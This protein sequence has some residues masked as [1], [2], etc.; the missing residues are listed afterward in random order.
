MFCE[1]TVQP[2]LDLIGQALTR[3]L[4]R[5]ATARTWRS[6]FPDCSPRNL[7][8]R[9]K[10]DELDARLGLRTFNEIRKSRGLEPF[11]DP[12]FDKPMLPCELRRVGPPA[13]ASSGSTT[14]AELSTVQTSA[15]RR[16]ATQAASATTTQ[17]RCSRCPSTVP[18][19]RPARWP[20]T[21][22]SCTVAASSRPS[23]PTGP[24]TSS[25]P[26][27]LR[28]AEEYPAQPGRAVGAQPRRSSRRSACA[29][30]STCS[31]DGS[32]PRRGSP[33]GVPFA[34]DVFR[35]YEQG[36]LRGWSIGFVPRQARRAAAPRRLDR[37]ARR[38]VGPARIL[39]GADPGEPRGADAGRREG[40]GPRPRAAATG[41]TSDDRG[42]VL[43][44]LRRS[45]RVAPRVPGDRE[46]PQRL[47]HSP[48][49]R[50]GRLPTCPPW[51]LVPCPFLK[52]GVPMS[53]TATVP[54][55]Q[56]PVP[57]R[58]GHVHRGASRH[59][60]REGRR[61]VERRV[62][63]VTSGPVV[64]GLGRVQRAEGRR[65]RARLRRPR[66]GQGRDP[67]PPAAPRPVRGL[68]VHAA[69]RAA[70][71]PGAAGHGPPAGVRA[72]RP[73][74]PRRAAPEDDRPRRPVRPGRGRLDRPPRR[75]PAQGAR[76]DSAT[77]PAAR[78]CRCRCSAS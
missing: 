63:W 78:W 64:P 54:D 57:R 58:A 73:A 5:R 77:P 62:P 51:F 14:S 30:G 42:S 74:A 60:R 56:V 7:D 76:H 61:R 20:S 39:G 55:R 28:N 13:S 25:I 33:S 49:G 26:T 69:P 67:R 36:V 32:S 17:P 29:S 11:A 68:R 41:C 22:T 2:K 23:T 4:G 19:P 43:A 31:R 66:P 48:R 34:E 10:D 44:D 27:G 53:A 45:P 8:Q 9:R 12:R 70:V 3:D 47:T 50:R 71:V 52:R 15:S 37:P 24:A 6:S 75:A 18:I 35:L 65:V 59:G 16:S 1:G 72:A 40:T 46:A 21:P 38:G